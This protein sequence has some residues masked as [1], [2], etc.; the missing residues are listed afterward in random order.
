MQEISKIYF[1]N[2]VKEDLLDLDVYFNVFNGTN[3]E[4]YWVNDGVNDGV[5]FKNKAG[6][7]SESELNL[8]LSKLQNV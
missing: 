6:S 8:D 5:T 4:R 1:K 2:I 7:I 3:D